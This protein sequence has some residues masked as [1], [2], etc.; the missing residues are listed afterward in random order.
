MISIVLLVLLVI[1]WV[2]VGAWI[3]IKMKIDIHE[4][5]IL[6][7]IIIVTWPCFIYIKGWTLCIEWVCSALR[8]ITKKF[9]W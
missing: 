5:F 9:P 4:D 7:L 8:P 1:L 2:V 3:A 6:Y